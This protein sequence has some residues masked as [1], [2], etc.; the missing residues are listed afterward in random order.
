MSDAELAELRKT[1]ASPEAISLDPFGTARLVA[2]ACSDGNYDIDSQD[3][4]LRSLDQLSA[5]GSAKVIVN[6][7]V[8]ECGLFP[9]LN[10]D[11][12]GSSDLFAT[13]LH[14]YKSLD[15][16]F[17]LHREQRAILSLLLEK[18]SVVLSAPTSFGKSALIDAVLFGR[19]Y[20]H[21]L[22][23]VPTIAL[24][25][26]T[27]R[28]LTKRFSP[29]WK[30]IT[31]LGQAK[32][33]KNIFILTPE[34]TDLREIGKLEFFIVDEFYKLGNET[35]KDRHATLN[36]ICYR[37]LQMDI[38]FFMLGPNIEGI[39]TAL[40]ERSEFRK[41][42]YRTV[43]VNVINID[44]DPIEETVALC[45]SLGDSTIVF[46]RSPE[47]IIEMTNRL[48]AAGITT[49]KPQPEIAADWAGRTYHPEWHYARAMAHGI[50]VHHGSIPRSLAH[51]A[52]R[53]F[54]N[55]WLNFLFCTTTLIEGV[56]TR[57][58]SL[59]ILDSKV[60]KKDIDFFT[61]S[62]IKGRAGRMMQHF[63]GDVYTFANAPQEEL[64]FVDLPI[65]TQP[66]NTS[67]SI[68]LGMDAQDLRLR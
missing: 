19:I 33:D 63:V 15:E 48:I 31:H 51:W 38:P 39:P 55:G 4:V 9:Y 5:F 14:R 7:L 30:I 53:A 18:K 35:E 66:E 24:M 42:E 47:R 65:F 37:L 40:S 45:K 58:R 13:A 17:V 10:L 20:S 64:P 36:K 8:R 57:A 21:I 41:T 34:R 26:E 25:D 6:S 32:R 12:V 54:N 61:F 44:K 29:E 1:L 28:R 50:G 68:L 67:S 22:I 52:V 59:I 11:E 27:R 2:D 49:Q 3:L 16:E 62:N 46:C 56:N 60:N 43:A 23:L